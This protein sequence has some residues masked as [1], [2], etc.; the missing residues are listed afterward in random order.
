MNKRI[1]TGTQKQTITPKEFVKIWN[2]LLPNAKKGIK[3]GDVFPKVLFTMESEA[4]L[5]DNLDFVMS[6]V[7]S[8]KEFQQEVSEFTGTMVS[9]EA[10]MCENNIQIV[11]NNK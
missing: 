11:V 9:F 3:E 10:V 7:N 5:K 1:G 4:G 2:I 8:D 6:R